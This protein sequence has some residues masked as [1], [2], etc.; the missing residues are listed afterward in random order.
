MKT[1]LLIKIGFFIKTSAQNNLNHLEMDP[2]F[3][4]TAIN[5]SEA[6]QL[7]TGVRKKGRNKGTVH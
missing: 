6:T 5:C 1:S 3:T 4:Y 2:Q 7:A